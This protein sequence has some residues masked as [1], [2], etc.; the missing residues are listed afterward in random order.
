MVTEQGSL[1]AF[2]RSLRSLRIDEFCQVS[3][4]FWQELAENYQEL[5]ELSIKTA[6]DMFVPLILMNKLHITSLELGEV[7]NQVAYIVCSRLKGF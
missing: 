4:L 7:S 2:G 5:R 1:R 3:T 6:P